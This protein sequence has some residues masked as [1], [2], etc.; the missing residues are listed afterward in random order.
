MAISSRRL[1]LVSIAAALFWPKVSGAAPISIFIEPSKIYQ[2]TENNPCIFYGTH[3]GA[4]SN[5]KCSH[6]PAGWPNP[7]GQTGAQGSGETRTLENTILMT[8]WNA[9]SLPL[10]FVVGF[11]A[12]ESST[13]QTLD[14]FKILF[15]GVETYTYTSPTIPPGTSLPATQNGNGWADYLFT[16][17]CFAAT[18]VVG[19]DFDHCATNQLLPFII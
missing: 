19:S 9:A 3:D 1:V 13:S 5:N 6:D 4:D 17:N 12:N 14:Y 2:N 15:N 7:V 16:A 10:F 8:D 11:D 18:D